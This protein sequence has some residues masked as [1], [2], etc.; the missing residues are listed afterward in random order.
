M[1]HRT[2]RWPGVLS[3]CLLTA[4]A[5]PPH[6]EPAAPQGSSI[7]AAFQR[8]LKARAAAGWAVLGDPELQRLR[9][10]WDELDGSPRR[11]YGL[12]Y[13]ERTWRARTV[14]E[15]RAVVH[16]VI[17]RWPQ[18]FGVPGRAYLTETYQAKA[19]PVW[20]FSFAQRFGDVPVVDG[21][22]DVRVHEDGRLLMLGRD[23]LAVPVGFPTKPL[24]PA[25]ALTADAI[26]VLAVGEDR[27]QP[28]AP[29]TLAIVGRT[30]GNRREPVLVWQLVV[31]RSEPAVHGRLYLD[32]RREQVGPESVVAF[33]RDQLEARVAASAPV[34]STPP[35]AAG[36]RDAVPAA[37]IRRRPGRPG[38]ITGRVHALCW[39]GVDSADPPEDVGL[40]GIAIDLGAGTYTLADG[41]FAVDPTGSPRA[42][43]GSYTLKII[44]RGQTTS[45]IQSPRP[46][47]EKELAV[48]D[49][50][51]VDVP[52]VDA[53]GDDEA[54]AQTTHYYC[55]DVAYR[56]ITD[57]FAVA[58]V[59]PPANCWTDLVALSHRVNQ[60]AC[61]DEYVPTW[62]GILT[63]GAGSRHCHNGAVPSLVL[64]EWGH[65]LDT[66]LGGYSMADGMSEGWADAIAA[67]L[68][69]DAEIG[70][71]QD[72]DRPHTAMRS[73]A[74]LVARPLD[75]RWTTTD[76][77]EQGL[78]WAGCLWR[79]HEQVG[80]QAATSLLCLVLVRNPL[81]LIDAAQGLRE[82]VEFSTPELKT[83]VES[84]LAERNL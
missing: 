34:V 9:V 75:G 56:T 49:A 16:E 67:F 36:V 15:A 4:C 19:G 79:L 65:A 10:R 62:P 11:I 1:N 63:M 57:W 35:A 3:T 6:D 59:M 64:H 68:L 39:L 42:A 31:E 60:V 69:G 70:R 12:D 20:L 71:G 53:S 25:T 32:A 24:L 37:P 50:Q 76:K 52:M 17:E 48:L 51:D 77:H 40:P 47:V 33:V 8:D 46:R 73:C 28:T 82:S 41:T 27:L 21:R 80:A 14:D 2:R 81:D 83:A 26:G 5:A 45:Q 18:L 55:V 74:T 54:V 13:R 72:L 38:T 84:A 78:C 30:Q 23:T 43:N 22:A 7:V 66:A 44:L 58:A 61:V 29:P